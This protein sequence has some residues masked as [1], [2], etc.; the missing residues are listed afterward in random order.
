MK[1]VKRTVEQ[2]WLKS[3]SSFDRAQHQLCIKL[4]SARAKKKTTDYYMDALSAY[5]HDLRKVF[6][7]VNRLAGQ[8]RV[9]VLPWIT[10]E[11]SLLEND[12]AFFD[13]KTNSIRWDIQEKPVSIPCYELNEGS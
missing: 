6:N 5:C 12:V 4:Y 9:K 8:D 1:R 11:E 13:K 10:L 7:I 2:K 3:Q